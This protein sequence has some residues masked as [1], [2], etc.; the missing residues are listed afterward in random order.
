M[1]KKTKPLLLI[2]LLACALSACMTAQ[3]IRDRRIASNPEIFNSLSPEIQQKI[4]A[5]QIEL[6]FSEEMVR[7][8]W[9]IPD[10]IYTRTTDQGEATVWTYSKTR[11]LTQTDRMTVPVQV[12]DKSGR[13]SV[14]YENVWINRD[15]REEY[16]VA[17]VEFTAGTVTAL[18]RLDM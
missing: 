14:Q 11:I 13:S 6:G 1:I 7:L 4:R 18:E 8:A 2:L 16:T 9:G 12:R 5:G 3:Q 17:R 10:K 15:T